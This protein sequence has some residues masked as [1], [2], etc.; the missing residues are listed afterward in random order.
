[1]D[2]NGFKKFGF[3]HPLSLLKNSM[4][5]KRLQRELANFPNNNPLLSIVDAED[6]LCW[7]VRIKGAEGT[8][9]AGEEFTLEA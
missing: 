1:L 8:L 6:L 5:L 2:K 7:R 4:Y 9:Y 3:P